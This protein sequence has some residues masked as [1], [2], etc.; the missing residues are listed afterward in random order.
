MSTLSVPLTTHHEDFI[1]SMV[2]QGYAPTKAEVVRRALDRL[3]E[4]EAVAVVLRSEQE[5][6]EGKV[7]Y[8]DLRK[9][10][11]MLP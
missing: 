10:A 2:K 1:R 8:G 6:K 11:K 5:L 3:A 7:F 9:L 4:D